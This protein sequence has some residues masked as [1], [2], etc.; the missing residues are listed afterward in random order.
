MDTHAK[1][2]TDTDLCT[3]AS[4]HQSSPPRCEGTQNPTETHR[5]MDRRIGTRYAKEGGLLMLGPRLMGPYT[6]RWLHKT[7]TTV[8]ASN[9]SS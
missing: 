5:W 7:K 3:K 4:A 6:R 2:L 8:T 9:P 1:E